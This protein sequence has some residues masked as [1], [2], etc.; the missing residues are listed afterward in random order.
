MVP[1]SQSMAPITT[2]LINFTDNTEEFGNSTAKAVLPTHLFHFD[3]Y[4]Q[5][6]VGWQ[7]W[8][9]RILYF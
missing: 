1:D 4:L 6:L 8:I 3:Q 2:D 7:Q 9:P 5:L